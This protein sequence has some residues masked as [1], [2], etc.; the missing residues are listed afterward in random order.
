MPEDRAIL[1][2]RCARFDR[3]PRDVRDAVL[4]ALR[5]AG[6]GF[7]A[8][9]D[10]CGLAARR[11]PAL[12]RWAAQPDLRV[13]AC[14]PRTA[15]WLFHAA[16]AELADEKTK[17]L[18][19][20]AQPAEQIVAALLGDGTPCQAGPR[21]GRPATTPGDA[22]SADGEE[23]WLPWFPV[24][25]YDR[26]AGCGQCAGFCLFGVYTVEGDEKPVV[27]N[28]QNC[29]TNCPACARVCPQVAIIFPK[30]PS[31]PISGED[32]DE[33]EAAKA[34]DASALQDLLRGDARA[35]LQARS[36]AASAA[37]EPQPGAELDEIARRAAARGNV[38][39]SL[40]VA[41]AADGEAPPPGERDKGSCCSDGDAAAEKPSP[42]DPTEHGGDR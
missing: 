22:A 34:R 32:V 25:D 13:V 5:E 18:N 20:R 24:I 14:W 12:R 33:G 29:K 40:D 21:P 15:K 37:G 7:E 4:G 42:Q 27:A 9:D 8:V 19:M 26:C 6:A 39:M 3:V 1:F 31:G 35:V 11:D 2:C 17:V 23:S 28:P 41:P 10:L 16:G 30:F 36:A 38:L